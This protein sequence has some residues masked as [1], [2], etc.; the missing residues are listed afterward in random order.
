M[1]VYTSEYTVPTSTSYGIAPTSGSLVHGQTDY[2]ACRFDD[3]L[4]A[5]IQLTIPARRMLTLLDIRDGTSNTFFAGKAQKALQTL[6]SYQSDDNEGYCAGWVWDTVHYA[7][8]FCPTP[9]TSR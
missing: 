4:G 8:A 9:P 3:Q 6:G 2:G 7:N 1:V 5:M